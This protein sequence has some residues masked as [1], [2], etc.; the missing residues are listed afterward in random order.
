LFYCYICPEGIKPSTETTKSETE[1]RLYIKWLQE[2]AENEFVQDVSTH[3]L[4]SR[5]TGSLNRRKNFRLETWYVDGI[6]DCIVRISTKK[7]EGPKAGTITNPTNIK[8]PECP[9]RA[10]V[11]IENE[12]RKEKKNAEVIYGRTP[13]SSEE[14]DLTVSGT[15]AMFRERENDCVCRAR[16]R[17]DSEVEIAWLSQS[18]GAHSAWG[19]WIKKSKGFGYRY[20]PKQERDEDQIFVYFTGKGMGNKFSNRYFPENNDFRSFMQ[21]VVKVLETYEEVMKKKAEGS[22]RFKKYS[23]KHPKRAANALDNIK[24]AGDRED[25]HYKLTRRR[26]AQRTYSSR[27]DSPVMVRLLQ[28]IE[29]AQ[30]K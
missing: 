12:R 2:A 24:S 30:D 28:E 8:V 7:C 15:K 6:N 10:E 14:E 16:G 3:E 29:A 11:C 26:M 25:C 1:P 13:S 17:M 18:F 9:I 19:S 22:E 21:S 4:E 23:R 5:K 27:R 20:T